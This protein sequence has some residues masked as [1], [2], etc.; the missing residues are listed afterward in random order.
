M[1]ISPRSP[2]DLFL[3]CSIIFNLVASDASSPEPISSLSD[4]ALGLGGWFDEDCDVVVVAGPG[5]GVRFCP[6]SAL[7]VGAAAH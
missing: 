2:A 5:F 7:S 1:Y 6:L 4:I 3:F